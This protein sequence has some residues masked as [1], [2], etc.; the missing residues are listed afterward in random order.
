MQ[1]I[2]KKLFTYKNKEKFFPILE[3]KSKVEKLIF[4]SVIYENLGLK[5]LKNNIFLQFSGF[6]WEILQKEGQKLITV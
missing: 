3:R 4:D 1:N 6:F 2:F 5:E